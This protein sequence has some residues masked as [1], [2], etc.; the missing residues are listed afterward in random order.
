MPDQEEI[1]IEAKNLKKY[2]PIK[3]GMFEKILVANRGEIAVRIIRA[4]KE[5]QHRIKILWLLV[6]LVMAVVIFSFRHRYPLR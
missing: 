6:V 2:F 3:S 1:L 4:C 5:L